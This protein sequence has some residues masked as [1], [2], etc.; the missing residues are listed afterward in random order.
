MV[1]CGTIV[2]VSFHNKVSTILLKDELI[3]GSRKEYIFCILLLSLPVMSQL[4]W[5]QFCQYLHFWTLRSLHQSLETTC[6]DW[7]AEVW[8]IRQAMQRQNVDVL[9]H[10]HT[11]TSF[12]LPCLRS[13][14]FLQWEGRIYSYLAMVGCISSRNTGS[15]WGLYGRCWS[16]CE[17]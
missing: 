10:L 1:P 7:V 6:G 16:L 2:M 15:P 12:G 14:F 8:K 9:T 5:L 17:I 3:S 13:F 11:H 4:W